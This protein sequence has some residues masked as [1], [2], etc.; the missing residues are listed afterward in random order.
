MDNAAQFRALYRETYGPLRR[1]AHHRGVTGSDADDVV[2]ETFTIAWRRYDDIPADAVIPWLYGVARNVLRNHRRGER[3]RLALVN[4]L[5]APSPVPPPDE[6][7]DTTLLLV[8][9]D[10]LADDDQ[11]ILRLV[12]W[13]GLEPSEAA[14]A[15]G[16]TGSAARVRLH[17]ARQ[18]F[19]D[20]V[21]R[22][23]S[24][25][26]SGQRERPLQEVP[27]VG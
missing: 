4:A 15:L 13:D 25:T 19:V 17:R 3:R 20:A 9:L 27:D 22:V 11:E 2:A 21:T 6:P 8:A 10:L 5:P 24:Q 26:R 1:W 18:R 14:V 7:S 23:E 16:I 12:A